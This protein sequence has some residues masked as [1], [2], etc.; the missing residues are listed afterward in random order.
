MWILED[1]VGN[2]SVQQENIMNSGLRLWFQA[3]CLL[4]EQ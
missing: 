3:D 1:C 2:R 4:T